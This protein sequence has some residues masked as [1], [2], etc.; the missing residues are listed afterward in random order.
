MTDDELED[1]EIAIEDDALNVDGVAAALPDPAGEGTFSEL[2]NSELSDEFEALLKALA[3]QGYTF[4]LHMNLEFELVAKELEQ[5]L[6]LYADEG[7]VL[8]LEIRRMSLACK[9]WMPTSSAARS[10]CRLAGAAARRQ[11][12]FDAW[13]DAWI[14]A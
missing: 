7:D 11:D 13:I 5:Q 12:R 1:G 2:E 6:Q 9:V 3:E 8:L 14:D 10:R 4:D